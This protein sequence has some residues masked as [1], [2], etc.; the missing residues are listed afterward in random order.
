MND[1]LKDIGITAETLKKTGKTIK[2]D[3]K[4]PNAQVLTDKEITAIGKLVKQV[5]QHYKCP[6]DT[7]WAVDE[8]GRLHLLQAR[9]ITTI[10]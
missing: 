3:I 10:S 5:E 7:E 2:K 8:K 9:P 1:N 4:N 6:Q